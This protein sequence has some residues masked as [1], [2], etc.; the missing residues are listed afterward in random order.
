MNTQ[1]ATSAAGETAASK[2]A[3]KAS[4]YGGSEAGALIG[5][6]V[7]PPIIGTTSKHKHIL[8]EI[9]KDLAYLQNLSSFDAEIL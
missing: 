7:G 1:P 3:T 6:A 5:G 4:A 2:A 8:E 9:C